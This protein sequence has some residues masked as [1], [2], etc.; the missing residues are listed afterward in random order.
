L[1]KIVTVFLITILIV[2]AVGCSNVEITRHGYTYR[3]ENEQWSA[4]YKV[5]GFVKI[6]KSDN[7]NKY[8]TYEENLLTVTFKNDIS[9]L[10]NIKNME[11]SYT[12]GSGGGN[13]KQE[14]NQ[15][16]LKNIYTMR[17]SGRGASI[18]DG[19]EIIEVTI[20]LDGESQKFYLENIK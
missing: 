18:M 11:I 7:K 14:L 6:T 19:D 1:K 15:H 4:E 10:S 13:L 5:D 3:G 8:E 16:N 17:T 20:T 12:D 2:S 9:E